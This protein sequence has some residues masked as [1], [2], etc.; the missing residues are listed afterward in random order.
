[1]KFVSTR[2]GDVAN[3]ADALARGLAADGGLYVPQAIPTV[4]GASP[5]A[6]VA[7]TAERFI[8][9]YVVGSPLEAH[10]G[11]ICAEAFT[12]DAPLRSLDGEGDT[13][14]ELFHG[15]TAAFKDFG[16]RFLAGSLA[17]LPRDR[18]RDLVILV[19]TSGDTGAAVAAAFDRRP[20]FRV[21]ILYPDGGVSARQA[22][23]LSC[24]GDNVRTY[25]VAASFD[26]CQRVVKEVLAAHADDP[27]SR[28]SSANSISLGR[29]LPQIAYHAHAALAHRQGSDQPLNLL[30]PS[31][32]LGDGAAA[33]L[34]RAMGAP[35]G[36]IDFACNA[37]LVLPDFFAGE[38][39]RP[40]AS[41]RTLANAMDIGA[42]SNFE[43]LVHWL[44]GEDGVRAAFGCASVS[45]A[46]I[47]QIIAA[48][49]TRHGAIVCPHTACGL[50]ML[51]DKRA[52]GDT[53]PWAVAATAH[54]AK[55][56]TIVEPLVGHKVAVP[57]ALAGY[58][59]RPTR[60]YPL[61]PSATELLADLGAAGWIKL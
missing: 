50:A 12:F 31:G 32:N 18:A 57:P 45:D 30:I 47:E 60:N 2:G 1:M 15:P 14:L 52:A 49:P 10:L 25:R 28:F 16:A 40:R 37:N 5:S 34:A 21:V 41:V 22:Q 23:G 46:R 27:A 33:W 59:A 43:R 13:L 44:G 9:P 29:L 39:Y 61:A 36:D 38:A 11:E 8:A 20:G 42:P 56:E 3:L 26:E 55:F 6:S 35:I 58:L 53:R 7:A 19:A 48:A 24:F 51:E 4:D 17:R 54:P